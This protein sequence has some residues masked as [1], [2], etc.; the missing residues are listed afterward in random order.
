MLAN[1]GFRRLFVADVISNVGD[2]VGLLTIMVVARRISGELGVAAVFAARL[3]P[4]LV[5][6]PLS[7]VLADR[8]DRLRTML[9]VNLGRAAVL[10]PLPF[11]NSLAVLCLAAFALEA[12]ADLWNPVRQSSVPHLVKRE[13]LPAANALTLVSVYGTLP[14]GSAML[15]VLAGIAGAAPVLAAGHGRE[16]LA[17]WFDALTFLV[18]A[19]LLRRLHLPRREQRETK[20]A[21][22]R[23]TISELRE[24]I[25]F[26]VHHPLVRVVVVCL[27]LAIGL[28][29]SLVPLSLAFSTRVLGEGTAGFGLLTAALGLGAAATVLVVSAFGSRRPNRVIFA[30]AMMLAGAAIFVT[31]TFTTLPVAMPGMALAGLGAGLAYSTGIAIVQESTPD[32]LRGRAFGVLNQALR[33]ALLASF[34]LWPVVSAGLQ[35]LFGG[36]RVAAFGVGVTLVGVRL[37]FWL[38]GALVALVGFVAMTLVTRAGAV[39][40]AGGGQAVTSG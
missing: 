16:G 29:S 30:V 33:L 20:K 7:G 24:G 21:T 35:D 1:P 11:T 34:T 13:D 3:V 22:V 10:V 36:E 38:S 4:G 2:W 9:A 12:Q 39:V 37:V 19:F 28:G 23:Q 32:A 6:G 5:L 17:L 18:S 8:W 27:P 40:E 15:A 26:V 25:R 31:A 14:V